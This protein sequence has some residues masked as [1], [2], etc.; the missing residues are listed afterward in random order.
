MRVRP[1]TK[2]VVRTYVRK[3]TLASGKE[4]CKVTMVSADNR[5]SRTRK[6]MGRALVAAREKMGV[7]R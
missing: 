7:R 3:L 1:K 4:A 6:T 2:T 5:V